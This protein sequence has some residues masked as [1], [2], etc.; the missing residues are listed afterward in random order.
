[1][2]KKASIFTKAVQLLDAAAHIIICNYLQLQRMI[3]AHYH[4][5]STDLLQRSQFIFAI[6]AINSQFEI[7]ACFRCTARH[8]HLLPLMAG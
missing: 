5:K 2:V 4:R 7:S 8:G 1:M 3:I 6:K